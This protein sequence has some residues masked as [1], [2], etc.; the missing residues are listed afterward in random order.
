MSKSAS[1]S[2]KA[3]ATKLP[4]IP[5]EVLEKDEEWVYCQEHGWQIHTING[6][7][8]CLRC[9]LQGISTTVMVVSGQVYSANDNESLKA[10]TSELYETYEAAS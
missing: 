9:K 5:D 7:A 1:V 4:P 3:R 6:P 10:R 2:R 8:G